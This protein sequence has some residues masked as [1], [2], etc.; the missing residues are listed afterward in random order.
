MTRATSIG[1]GS[2]SPVGA[3]MRTLAASS[4]PRS[5]SFRR[6]LPLL[7]PLL[8]VALTTQRNRGCNEEDSRDGTPARGVRRGCVWQEADAGCEGSEQHGD[9]GRRQGGDACRRQQ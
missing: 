6:R 1:A 9:E 3:V 7:A 2:T 5:P 4:R 8:V